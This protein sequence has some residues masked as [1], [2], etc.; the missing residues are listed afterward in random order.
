MPQATALA[1][2]TPDVTVKVGQ[3]TGDTLPQTV[4]TTHELGESAGGTDGRAL[5]A[6]GFEQGEDLELLVVA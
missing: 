2:G 5:S 1:P 4:E 6:D 3:L